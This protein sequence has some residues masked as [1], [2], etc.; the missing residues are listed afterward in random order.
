MRRAIRTPTA[1]IIFVNEVQLNAAVCYNTDLQGCLKKSSIDA[2]IAPD[3][4]FLA[5]QDFPPLVQ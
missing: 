4:P 3:D 5:F 2:Q 1:M